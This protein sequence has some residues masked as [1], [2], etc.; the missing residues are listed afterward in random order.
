M[1]NIESNL[2]VSRSNRIKR[3]QVQLLP[4]IC[5]FVYIIYINQRKW[6]VRY[7]STIIKQMSKVIKERTSNLQPLHQ[8][9]YYLLT[10]V[11]IERRK[12]GANNGIPTKISAEWWL[13]TIN[14]LVNK[15]KNPLWEPS[16]KTRWY[17]PQFVVAGDALEPLTNLRD[18]TQVLFKEISENCQHN[19]V[20]KFK[21]QVLSRLGTRSSC[22]NKNSSS[23]LLVLVE[24][25]V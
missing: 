23:I 14:T 8:Q 2:T 15:N 18:P 20:G 7:D 13:I 6:T 24:F 4:F 9:A 17:I 16:T 5:V 3:V 21:K 12:I 1:I 11:P 22:D 10:V 25:R 19:F